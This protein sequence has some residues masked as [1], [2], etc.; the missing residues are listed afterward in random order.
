MSDTKQFLD[1][2]MPRLAEAERALHNGDPEPRY[3]TWS[4]DEPTVFG[5]WLTATG[6]DDVS[7]IFRTI[8]SRFSDST[9]SDFELVTAGASGDLAY[10]VGYERT[11]TNVDGKERKYTLRCTQIYRRENGVWKVCHRHA[12]ELDAINPRDL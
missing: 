11:T 1:E 9:Q 12:D 2:M 8:A 3:E 5:A 7:Q 6:W 10:T 4:H